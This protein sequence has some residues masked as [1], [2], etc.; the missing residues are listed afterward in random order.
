[1]TNLITTHKTLHDEHIAQ[2]G[3]SLKA[4]LKANINAE[5]AERHRDI[6]RIAKANDQRCTA[7]EKLINSKVGEEMGRLNLRIEIN[8]NEFINSRDKQEY[9]IME[10]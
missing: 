2:M 6:E 4:L 10:L 9:K 7:I 1:M 8:R 5:T 3:N